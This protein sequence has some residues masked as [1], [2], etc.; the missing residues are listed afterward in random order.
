MRWDATATCSTDTDDDGW[1]GMV[2]AIAVDGMV[3]VVVN[4]MRSWDMTKFRN[5]RVKARSQWTHTHTRSPSPSPL[6]FLLP[7]AKF[8]WKRQGQKKEDKKI[9]QL[10]SFSL[11][12]IY[13]HLHQISNL[14]EKKNCIKQK[15]STTLLVCSRIYNTLLF[16]F[17]SKK[18]KDQKIGNRIKHKQKKISLKLWKALQFC[19]LL[20]YS[21]TQPKTVRSFFPKKKQTDSSLHIYLS[22]VN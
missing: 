22:C 19:F 18:K 9:I 5:R 15:Y 3:A 16:N 6:L 21:P 12:K 17:F 8:C 4:G 1:Y 7:S 14:K 2:N 20:T 10:V 11:Q 13:Y